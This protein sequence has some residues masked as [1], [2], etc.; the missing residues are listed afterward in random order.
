MVDPE[1]GQPQLYNKK[2]HNNILSH[3]NGKGR[4]NWTPNHKAKLLTLLEMASYGKTF[5]ER[6]LW[7]NTLP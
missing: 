1:R 7:S 6:P 5:L 4:N 2:G 3:L